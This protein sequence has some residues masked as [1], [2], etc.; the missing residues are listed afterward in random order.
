MRAPMYEGAL[1]V[2]RCL[3]QIAAFRRIHIQTINAYQAVLFALGTNY[4]KH[5][6]DRPLLNQKNITILIF[7]GERKNASV[8]STYLTVPRKPNE[9]IKTTAATIT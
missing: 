2:R 3:Q 9:H 7:F 1:H 4:W 8:K 6:N 5:D